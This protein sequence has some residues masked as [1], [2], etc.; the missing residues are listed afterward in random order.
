MSDHG[1]N[2]AYADDCTEATAA[3]IFAK[4]RA[5]KAVTPSETDQFRSVVMLW[6]GEQYHARAWVMQLHLG[7]L[8]NNNTRMMRT[9]GADTGFDSIGDWPQAGP[10]ARYLDRLDQVPGLEP[11][12]LARV[13]AHERR[14]LEDDIVELARPRLVGADSANQR[15][16]P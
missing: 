11:R 4:A 5:G 6:L 12:L 7:A 10:L 2:H 16:R 3:N 8:R 14:A 9:L 1:L 13:T 15:A